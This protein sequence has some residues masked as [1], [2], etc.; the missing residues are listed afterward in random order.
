MSYLVASGIISEAASPFCTAG[1][2]GHATRSPLMRLPSAGHMVSSRRDPS[3]G[4]VAAKP[5]TGVTRMS[6]SVEVSEVQF[7]GDGET[8]AHVWFVTTGA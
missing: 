4:W 1:N 8:H 3:D 2:S 6:R 7:S 5:R